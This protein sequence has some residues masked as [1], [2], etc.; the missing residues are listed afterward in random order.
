MLLEQ[1]RVHPIKSCRPVLRTSAQVEARGLRHDRRYMVVDR[2]GTFVTLRTLPQLSLIDVVI[3]SDHY[4]VALPDGP[5]F[6]IPWTLTEGPW[7]RVGVWGDAV[8]AREHTVAGE[9]LSDWAGVALRLVFMDEQESERNL[10]GGAGQV[11]FADAFP[12]LCVSSETVDDISDRVGRRMETSRFRPNL[13]VSAGR[14]YA[15][16]QFASVRIGQVTFRGASLCSRCVATTIDPADATMG[17]EPLTTLATYRRFDRSVYVG[18]NLIPDADGAIRVGDPVHV[19]T[20][21]DLRPP[22]A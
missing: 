19:L 20:S 9:L 12:L 10:P 8:V 4:D 14:P 7:V 21:A 11:S 3:E 15:E 1:I 16:D 18:V 17:T 2:T 13:V 22:P 6:Q 5:S